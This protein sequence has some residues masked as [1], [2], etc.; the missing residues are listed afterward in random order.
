MEKFLSLAN[1]W[2]FPA[3]RWDTTPCISFSAQCENQSTFIFQPR[4]S[5]LLSQRKRQ[6]CKLNTLGWHWLT[7][8]TFQVFNFII[9][10]YTLLCVH[11]HESLVSF[12][13][14][15]FDPL[16]PL[17]RHRM[18]LIVYMEQRRYWC[19][20][21]TAGIKLGTSW[22]RAMPPQRGIRGTEKVYRLS[23][24]MEGSHGGVRRHLFIV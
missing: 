10:L 9:Y 7:A 17:C 15:A 13:D 4:I 20:I 24:L 5:P 8:Y 6:L 12:H 19:R 2:H 22:H 18:P 21:C 23:L 1:K 11:H 3:R 14:L 16:Q